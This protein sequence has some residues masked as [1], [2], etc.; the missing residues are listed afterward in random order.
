M[1]SKRSISHSTSKKKFI[2]E[3]KKVR[4]HKIKSPLNNIKT[5]KSMYQSRILIK[6]NID[7]ERHNAR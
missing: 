5:K 1:K 2:N 6:C 4:K 3:I 7:N